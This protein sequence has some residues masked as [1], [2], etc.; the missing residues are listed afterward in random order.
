MA[1]SRA[2]ELERYFQRIRTDLHSVASDP[3]TGIALS[4]FNE[5]F[6]GLAMEGSATQV[7]KDAYIRNNPNP[8][9]E[10]HLLD[11]AMTGTAYDDVHARYHPWMRGHLLD[12][13]YYDIF[14]FNTRGDLIYS[15][16]KEE[17]FA[18]N[19]ARD[20]GEWSGTD[21]GAAFRGAMALESGG[22]AFFDFAP[23]APSNDAPASFMSMPVFENGERIGVVAFQ[24]PIDGINTIMSDT[25]GL[26]ETG[27]A[28]I[29][30]QDRLLRNDSR[31]T[32]ESDI[33]QARLDAEAVARTCRP[34]S[35]RFP[36]A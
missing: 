15:V 28:L 36:R 1:S 31:Y 33:L 3:T 6:A 34:A 20:G 26:G 21:L 24:M 7:L 4:E 25:S 5:A 11:A 13:G 10:K 16:F 2:H 14:F 35:P 27:E 18:T 9:G 22:F 8:L 23:Y 12:N 19:F 17:D 32:A 30:G 29:V